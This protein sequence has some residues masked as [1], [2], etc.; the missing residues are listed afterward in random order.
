MVNCISLVLLLI[1]FP[2]IHLWLSFTTFPFEERLKSE[3][4]WTL[5]AFLIVDAI[6][7]Q[8]ELR[9]ACIFPSLMLVFMSTKHGPLLL[10][11]FISLFLFYICQRK[12]IN[13]FWRELLN[14]KMNCFRLYVR[15]IRYCWKYFHFFYLN[16]FSS[17][18]DTLT[19]ES[20]LLELFSVKLAFIFF[21]PNVHAK[22]YIYQSPGFSN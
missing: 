11:C 12:K 10:H 15:N 13:I 20:Q 18:I 21:P 22:I 14:R 3:S 8:C 16:S 4:V 19:I 6:Y 9:C 17:Y 5:H 1:H 7:A 2:C